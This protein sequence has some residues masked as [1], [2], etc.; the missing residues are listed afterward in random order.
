MQQTPE[1]PPIVRPFQFGLGAL[2][3]VVAVAAVV[4]AVSRWLGVEFGIL[5]AVWAVL[6]L[7]GGYCTAVGIAV[8]A[9]L[10]GLLTLGH[11]HELVRMGMVEVAIKGSL[12]IAG[13]GG[14]IGGGFGALADGKRRLGVAI[15]V[16]CGIMI[17]LYLF[18]PAIQT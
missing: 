9:I 3:V 11:T 5:L 18:T 1:P 16:P 13:F 10:V 14:I 7:R 15:L 6:L 17:A 2:L 12:G 8:G 4:M